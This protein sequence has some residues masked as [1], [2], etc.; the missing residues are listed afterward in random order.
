MV[1]DALA[2]GLWSYQLAV[3]A[4]QPLG[5]NAVAYWEHGPFAFALTGELPPAR[6]LAL[7]AIIAS[8]RVVPTRLSL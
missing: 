8:T 3:V 1:G 7:A 5:R 6:M 2:F 4:I